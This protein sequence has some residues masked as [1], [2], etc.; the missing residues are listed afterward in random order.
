MSN[1]M[2]GS[3]ENNASQ[4]AGLSAP[5]SASV[6]DKKRNLLREFAHLSSGSCA[7][8]AGPLRFKSLNSQKR[9]SEL[10]KLHTAQQDAILRLASLSVLETDSQQVETGRRDKHLAGPE[11]DYAFR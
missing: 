2:L 11:R 9:S 8:K 3:Q 6:S 4:A 5:A 7:D 1:L 10:S